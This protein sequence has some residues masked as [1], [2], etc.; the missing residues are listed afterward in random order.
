MSGQRSVVL[1][2]PAG[3]PAGR[4]A[5]RQRNGTKPSI[6][7]VSESRRSAFELYTKGAT[8]AEVSAQLRMARGKAIQILIEFISA[9]KPA[10]VGAWVDSD[11]YSLVQQAS[12][13][14]GLSSPARIHDLVRN[15]VDYE[16]VRV[17]RAHLAALDS[18]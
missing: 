11:K 15:E 12:Q 13:R 17:V 14:V 5:R 3:A 10:T 8:P 4:R 9:T 6:S 16:T 1:R 2:Q 7:E 18:Q